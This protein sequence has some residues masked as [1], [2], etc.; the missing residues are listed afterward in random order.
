MNRD[1]QWHSQEILLVMF[2]IVPDGFVLTCPVFCVIIYTAKEAVRLIAF[3]EYFLCA[4]HWV[5]R[6]RVDNC[7]HP[8][9]TGRV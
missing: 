8:S 6:V 2:R 4:E 9:F 7:P 5:K 1:T 3:I